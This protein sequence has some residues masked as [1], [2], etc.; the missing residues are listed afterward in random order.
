MEARLSG[1]DIAF[2]APADQDDEEAFLAPA[3]R[4]GDSRYDPAVVVDA[5][6]Q[7]GE[8]RRQLADALARLDARS[9][10]IVSRR[11]LG[12]H[13]PTLHQLADEYG[14]SAERIRQIEKGAMRKMRERIA[15]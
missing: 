4:L 11:W 9:R 10:D 6:E 15:V 12:E 7:A 8:T 14:V 1:R 2:D 3:N 13:K 5:A